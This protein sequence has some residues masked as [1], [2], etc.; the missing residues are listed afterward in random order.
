VKKTT[1][2]LCLFQ[3]C[4][5]AANLEGHVIP[6]PAPL[7]HALFDAKAASYYA[8]SGDAV[9]VHIAK[10]DADASSYDSYI[11]YSYSSTFGNAPYS[12]PYAY[13]SD[14]YSL[15]PAIAKADSYYANIVKR[16]IDAAFDGSKAYAPNSGSYSNAPYS[17]APII[18]KAASY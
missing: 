1:Y 7:F 2:F 10:R 17:H 18:V 4:F 14:P 3:V 8:N 6:A 11:P 13:G 16:E 12:N 15:A 9:S 5:F